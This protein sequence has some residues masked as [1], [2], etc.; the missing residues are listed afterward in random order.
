MQ[1]LFQCHQ[2]EGY[3][4]FLFRI[5]TIYPYN[6][7]LLIGNIFFWELMMS[8]EGF[9]RDNHEYGTVGEY[10]QQQIQPNSQLSIVSAFF[11]I[12]AYQQL[13]E[14]LGS[15]DRLRFLFGEPTFIKSMDNFKLVTWLVIQGEQK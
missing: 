13:K 8:H 15:I 10:L 1:N 11:T 4:R 2:I 6:L 5:S 12:Y 7:L 9:I 3:K 14:K